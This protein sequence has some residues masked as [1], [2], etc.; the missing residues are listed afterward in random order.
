VTSESPR[1]RRRAQSR[2]NLR[3]ELTV[4]TGASGTAFF[5]RMALRRQSF[6]KAVLGKQ[7]RMVDL[8]QVVILGRQPE[9]RDA[10]HSR[11]RRRFRKF[12]RRERFEIENSGPPKR[13][14]CC[15]VTAVS[16]PRRSRSIFASV[17]GEASQRDSALENLAHLTAARGVINHARGF[18]LHPLGKNR[19]PWIHTANRWSVGKIIEEEA[20]RVRNMLEG[21]TLRLHRQFS[22][23]LSIHWRIFANPHV[24]SVSGK[25]GRRRARAFKSNTS[26][27]ASAKLNYIR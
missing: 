8:G 4:P 25:P 3:P 23:H 18:V 20:G 10:I 16:A 19:R 1:A 6:R 9:D 7:R 12:D 14:T 26:Q 2:L 13:P 27:A 11:C 15:P 5:K 21:Q 17:F 24:F 22:R